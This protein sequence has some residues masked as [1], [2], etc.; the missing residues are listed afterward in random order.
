MPKITGRMMSERLGKVHF[1]LMLIGFN[2][3][4][5]PQHQ[6][7]L[8]GMQR[9]VA[10]YAE[11]TGYQDLN[12]LSTIGSFVLA[13][14]IAV[15]IVNWW[16]SLRRGEPA[17][18]DPWK[19]NTLEW[20]TTSPPPA[21]NFHSLPEIRSERP[22]FDAREGAPEASTSQRSES[23]DAGQGPEGSTGAPEEPKS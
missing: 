17:G 16:R 9:R 6:L 21:H 4:F 19:G 8:D 1:W 11:S 18:D 23:T 2:L 20:A 15:F 12:V 22:V 5:F 10:D 3:T 7:G 13:L 14:G